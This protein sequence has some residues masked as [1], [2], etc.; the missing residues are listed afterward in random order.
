MLWYNYVVCTSKILYSLNIWL[1]NKFW[2]WV[3]HSRYV[4]IYWV[5]SLISKFLVNLFPSC[6][7]TKF[8]FA[9]NSSGWSTRVSP[10]FDCPSVKL[11]GQDWS[12]DPPLIC[13][14]FFPLP[15]MSLCK[16]VQNS[17][18]INVQTRVTCPKNIQPRGT[19]RL[20]TAPSEC[21][22]LLTSMLLAIDI[23]VRPFQF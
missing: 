23:S 3:T 14:H 11:C 22:H 19:G 18:A 21:C 2:L 13:F 10:G 12:C 17:H 5:T 15:L 6:F 8:Y 1:A 20:G 4:S 9:L 7:E 16:D